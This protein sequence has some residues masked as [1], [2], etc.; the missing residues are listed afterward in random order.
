MAD[1]R[2]ARRLS[3][4]RSRPTA[5]TFHAPLNEGE[6]KT[7]DVRGRRQGPRRAA[8][9][10]ATPGSRATRGGKAFAVK[11]AGARSSCRTSATSTE[12]SRSRRSAWVK[13]TPNDTTGAIV[14]RMDE[15]DKYR[16]WDLWIEGDSVG[17]HIIN[18]WP[19][20][21]LK[22]VAE[23]TRCRTN[24]WTHVVVT[25]DGS[26]QGRPASRSTVDGEPQPTDVAADTLKNT[27]T[28]DGAAS[29]SA[30]GTRANRVNGVASAGP[31]PLR[32]RA[33]GGRG[34]AAG[35]ARTRRPSCSPSRPT[36]RTP[37]RSDELFDWWLGRMRQAVPASSTRKSRK[38]Q[39]EEARSRPAA[40][41]PTS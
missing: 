23:A 25:Y 32:P 28:D 24:Q 27:I 14:A 12:R 7:I 6:G 34:R 40:P 18:K 33:D 38:L 39:Q 20:D 2:E 9:A 35:R 5:C 4:A 15:R 17:T 37:P 11:P 29:R 41:S 30:S 8:R 16:G 26:R 21:A 22:V 31:A 13:L 10:T 36:K 19:D 1:D 3:P